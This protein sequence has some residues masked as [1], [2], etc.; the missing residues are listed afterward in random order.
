MDY[1]HYTYK[2]NHIDFNSD[3]YKVSTYHYNWHSGVEIL[4]LLKGRI[5]MSCNSEVFTM[6]P[7][8]AIIISPQVGH[9]TLA[10]EEDTTALVIHVS[11]EFFQYFDPNFGMYQFVL[12]S[13]K[14]NRYNQFFAS[15]RH[16][17]AQMMLLMVSGESPDRQLCLESHY[18][19]LTSDIYREIDA[20]K[21]IPV[22]TKPADMTVA[23]FDKM[24]A[25]IDENYQQKIELEDIAKI[26]GYNVNYTSQFFKR[27]LGV[28]FLEYVLRLRLRE[29]TVL[30]VNSNDGVAYIASSCGFADIKAFNVAFKKHFHT[31]PSEYRKQAKEMGRKTKL[32]DWKEIISTQENDIMEILQSC[33]AYRDDSV[34]SLELNQANQKLQ[35]VKEQLESV[36]RKLSS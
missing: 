6:E 5:D 14:T 11:K 23:T 17:A 19:S 35:D 4:I 1:F 13:D 21:T 36:V 24:I 15:L 3:I 31:T 9:A 26:G 8:D 18:L 20:V 28:S 33:V 10:L 22:H 30:L 32:H 27:Q 25:Y 29:A 7:L 12:R 34:Y 16:H 2:H